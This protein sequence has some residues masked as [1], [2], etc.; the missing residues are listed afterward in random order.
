MRE[1]IER[2]LGYEFDKIVLEK[3]EVM[4]KIEAWLERFSDQYNGL[5][6][7]DNVKI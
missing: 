2:S 6:P 7:D 3:K 5:T 1:N 4:I